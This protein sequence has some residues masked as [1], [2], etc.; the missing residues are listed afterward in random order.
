MRNV[1]AGAQLQLRTILNYRNEGRSIHEIL[2]D[3]SQTLLKNI[4][5]T[6]EESN[7]PTDKAVSPM[8]PQISLIEEI[9]E[10]LSATV[11]GVSEDIDRGLTIT[12]QIRNYAR[13]SELKRGNQTID[14]VLLLKDYGHRYRTLFKR[15][16]ID[17]IVEGLPSAV[18][19]ADETHMNSIFSNLV[20]NAIDALED[21][22]AE[23]QK[24]IRIK[25]TYEIEI[26][27]RF[28]IVRVC[29]NGSGIPEKHQKEIFEPFFSTK[30]SSGTGLGLGMV[31]RFVKLYDGKI[32]FQ[33]VM[34]EGATFTVTFMEEQNG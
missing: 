28:L 22:E 10:H 18:F 29:D 21:S 4:P 25:V 6:D 17:Y 11:A 31:K 16:G 8:L 7:T 12:N 9:A 24:V 1:L 33:S 27:K 13:M 23:R 32:G 2:Y 30:P 26:H 3:S 14:L 5:G 19:K 20:L 34:G 15:S